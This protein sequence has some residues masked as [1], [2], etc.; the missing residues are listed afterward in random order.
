MPPHRISLRPSARL[1]RLHLQGGVVGP[2]G[3]A[4]VPPAQ[5]LAE[6]RPFPP[7][8]A[9]GN[10]A[11]ALLRPAFA[12]TAD[13]V[14][15]CSI[16]GKLSGNQR[17]SMRAGRPRSQGDLSP[18]EGES[19]KGTDRIHPLGVRKGRLYGFTLVN[20]SNAPPH[21]AVGATLVVAPLSRAKPAVEPEGGRTRRSVSDY[22][23]AGAEEGSRLPWWT[24]SW[25]WLVWFWRSG[26]K[27]SGAINPQRSLRQRVEVTSA[28]LFWKRCAFPHGFTK[29]PPTRL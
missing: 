27:R 10:G 15:G 13:V 1:L 22:T 18:P 8:G 24:Q 16:A 6:P 7:L 12:V 26:A 5:S 20:D 25:R 21:A 23:V 17:D 14:A 4:G 9:T 28:G 19:R 29:S 11:L 2:P 3:S